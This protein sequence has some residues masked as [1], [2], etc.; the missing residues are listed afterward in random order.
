MISVIIVTLALGSD[1]GLG[2]QSPH[3]Q[4]YRA[5]EELYGSEK[6][7]KPPIIL[8]RA[9]YCAVLSKRYF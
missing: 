2:Q 5:N 1:I 4:Y 9:F 6:V 3:E 8:M 7:S